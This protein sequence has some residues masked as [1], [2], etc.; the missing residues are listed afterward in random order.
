VKDPHRIIEEDRMQRGV[1]G[2]AALILLAAG[3]VTASPRVVGPDDRPLDRAT[4]MAEAESYWVRDG[5]NLPV[6]LS[7]D[8]DDHLR[9]PD[10][11]VARLLVLD[12]VTGRPVPSGLLR[13]AGEGIPDSLATVDWAA[14]SGRL[15][16]GCR[17]DEPVELN[18]EGYRLKRL[19]LRPQ[20]RRVTVLLE[21]A[22]DLEIMVRP[23]AAGVLWLAQTEAISVL[24][25]FYAAAAKHLIADDGSLLVRDL[26]AGAE[27]EGVV[28]VPGKAPVVGHITGLPRRL[29]LG[30]GP[31][32]A[33]SGRVVDDAG[34]A[35]AGASIEATGAIESLGG[36]RYR[37][38]GRTDTEGRFTV[39]GLLAGEITVRACASHHACADA[40]ITLADGAA[41]EP[42]GF[43]LAPGHDL[44]L[45]IQNEFGRHAAGATVIDKAAFRRFQT[46]DD[47]VL[48]F[49]GVEPGSTFEL[50]VFGAGLRRWQ[51]R[52]ETD[53]PEVV[54]RIPAGGVLEWPILTH[55]EITGDEVTA[56]WSR[57]NDRGREI[58]EGLA[59]WDVGQ[60]L[61][62]ADGLDA[63]RH[64]LVVRLPGSATLISEVVE[65]GLGEELSLAAV[66][67][68]AG[69]A[70]GGRVIDGTTGQP[71]AGA[72]VTCEP[73][74]PHQFRKPHRLDHLQRTV[75]DA[76]GI[77]LLEGLD[78]GGCRAVVRAPGFAGWRRDGVEPNEVGVDLGDI[79]LDHGTTIVGRV[80]DR[81]GTPQAGVAVE[82]T[83]DAA[84]A[85]FAETAVR[86]DHDG[87]FRVAALPVGGWVV[88]A[89]RGEQTARA[90]IEGRAD[91][92]ASVELRLGGLRLEGEVW[93][94]DRPA[95]GGALVL[96][97]DGAR[98]DGI[99][100]MVQTDADQSRFFGVD[101]PPISIAVGSDGRFVSD[102]VSAGVYTASYTPPGSGGSP[103]SR[104][105][106]I[107]E[108]D[109]HRCLIQYSDAGLD[110]FVVDPD[111]LPV[112]GAAVWVQSRD[113]RNLASGFSDGDGAFAFVGLDPGKVRVGAIHE[114]FG[115]TDPVDI[116]LR[117]SDTTGPITLELEDPDG[118]ELSLA[119]RS[120]AGSLSGA[121][122]YLVGAETLIGF[123]DDRGVTG[124]TG[125]A[126]DRYRPCAAAFGGAAG[127]GP[128][129]ELG[130]GDRR[131]LE[132]DLGRGGFVE[133][134]VG[135]ME[136]L[137]ALRVFTADGIDLTSMLM[138]VSPPIPGP[139]GVRLGPLKADAYRI[140]VTMPEGPRQG[141]VESADG[142]TTVL[143]LR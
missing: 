24:S 90:T 20:T 46:D 124:F 16:I 1:A 25:P 32:L 84:Y 128:E 76:D 111:G 93:I 100:V 2:I 71:V 95:A 57:L 103:V 127:C 137:P 13:W 47:G 12:A 9:F 6:L 92:T 98:G 123:T 41:A 135:P 109:H 133:V 80:L 91:E 126:P 106:V 35:L 15:D 22:R 85:Y 37:Q 56:T 112:A 117:A 33:V 132:L 138:M 55:R 72:R 116:E 121:P 17:G 131:E 130:D 102:G 136:R 61:V 94:G 44:R 5:V 70:I 108:T 8:G 7:P 60:Q 125:V 62:R 115:D 63:G 53:R 11:A 114:E 96:S 74:S 14:S 52:V 78:P 97:T 49:K 65:I 83:E 30:L 139:D 82:I 28:V 143:D 26:D 120:A 81:S 23:P 69:L 77:F 142:E 48:V 10:L 141:A 50:E 119:V 43:R 107:P 38:Q 67:P 45:V 29:E 40:I 3:A 58:A 64:R 51:G 39:S 4:V 54:L 140:I 31:G 66:A 104:E 87:W 134:L 113:G 79:E 122:V 75:S 101:R 34:R 59:D 73:G 36:F 88:S 21:P 86:S 118:A 99:V 27:F 89:R 18:A 68:D 19:D 105:L 110:G 42:V 129:I